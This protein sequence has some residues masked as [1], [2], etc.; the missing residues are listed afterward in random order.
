MHIY[1]ALQGLMQAKLEAYDFQ[2][3]GCTIEHI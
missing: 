1:A 3:E 2:K